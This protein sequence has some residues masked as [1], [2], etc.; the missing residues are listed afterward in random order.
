MICES[1]FWAQ[2]NNKYST[3]ADIIRAKNSNPTPLGLCLT[4]QESTLLTFKL[5]AV[6]IIFVIFKKDV[7]AY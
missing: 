6:L 5:L 7:V 2:D 4:K 3:I 1:Y